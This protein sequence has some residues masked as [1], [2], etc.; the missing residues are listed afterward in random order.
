MGKFVAS[1]MPLLDRFFSLLSLVS[2]LVLLNPVTLSSSLT[3]PG[4][5][6]PTNKR[7]KS[8]RDGIEEQLV[9]DESRKVSLNQLL[10]KDNLIERD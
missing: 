9:H 4:T 2:V 1:S 3:S 5:G 10:S 8:L 6:S 7:V